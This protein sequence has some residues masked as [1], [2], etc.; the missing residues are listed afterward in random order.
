MR[1]LNTLENMVKGAAVGVA[2]VTSL[3]VF[4]TVGA[5]TAVGVAVGSAL[6]VTAVLYDEFNED[7]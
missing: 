6:G 5:I 4:G 2:V 3:P 1:I 7:D